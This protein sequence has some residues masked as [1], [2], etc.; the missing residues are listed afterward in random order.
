MHNDWHSGTIRNLQYLLQKWYQAFRI[1]WHPVI[2]PRS[3]MQMIHFSF[4]IFTTH[5][6]YTVLK[7]GENFVRQKFNTDFIEI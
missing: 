4:N 1:Q 7:I 6:E 3:E 5:N 2:G